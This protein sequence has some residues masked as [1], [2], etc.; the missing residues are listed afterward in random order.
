MRGSPS[1]FQVISPEKPGMVGDYYMY[2]DDLDGTILTSDP[3]HV[4]YSDIRMI[5]YYNN[6][7][8]AH[9]VYD[10]K[11]WES[12]YVVFSFNPFPCFDHECIMLRR[13]LFDKIKQITR[14][15]GYICFNCGRVADCE[16][17]LC[18]PMPLD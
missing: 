14:N 5:P 9:S 6:I 12:D 15:P 17:N 2:F 18:N 3:V 13:E 8:D 7:T 10:A 1:S 11:V 4:A 16:R